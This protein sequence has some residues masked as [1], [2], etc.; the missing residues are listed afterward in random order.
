MGVTIFQSLLILRFY[1]ESDATYLLA[2]FIVIT[3]LLVYFSTGELR[4]VTS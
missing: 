4:L 2:S 3:F 1:N